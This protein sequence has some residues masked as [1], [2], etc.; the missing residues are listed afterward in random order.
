[1]LNMRSLPAPKCH[2]HEL[3]FRVNDQNAGFDSQVS[4]LVNIERTLVEMLVQV[5][6]GTC[7]ESEPSGVFGPIGSNVDKAHTLSPV[8]KLAGHWRI[9]V[10]DNRVYDLVQIPLGLDWA[11]EVHESTTFFSVL[12]T[13]QK[14]LTDWS[15]SNCNPSIAATTIA[16]NAGH[17]PLR[18]TTGE[19][20]IGLRKT[21]I[22]T[23]IQ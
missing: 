11:H 21:V 4:A 16:T 2:S 1:M 9:G 14:T 19:I 15:D 6:F 22:S 17:F 18:I 13:C 7:P 5:D 23:Q 12:V 8:R 10:T 3:L 20:R